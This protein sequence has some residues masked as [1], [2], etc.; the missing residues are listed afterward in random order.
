MG[1]PRMTLP[2]DAADEFRNIKTMRDTTASADAAG[3]AQASAGGT[4]ADAAGGLP[5]PTTD[6]ATLR[7]DMEAFGYCMIAD[8]LS[9][10][11]VAALAERSLDQAAAEA[12]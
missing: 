5:V 4:L 9:V 2:D 11:E 7:S 8:A 6:A 1:L 10:A 3:E 12:A